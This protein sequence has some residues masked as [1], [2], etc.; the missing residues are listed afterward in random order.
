[1]ILDPSGVATAV[2]P[3]LLQELLPFSYTIATYRNRNN[4]QQDGG[5][6]VRYSP[7]VGKHALLNSWCA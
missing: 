7:Q 4:Y 3:A 6:C 1:M 2:E 5:M